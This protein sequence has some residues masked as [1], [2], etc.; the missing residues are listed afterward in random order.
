MGN[1]RW[2]TEKQGSWGV[3][4][5]GKLKVGTGGKWNGRMWES[6]NRGEWEWGK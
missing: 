5:S 1:I 2:E 4:E 3:V 6:E